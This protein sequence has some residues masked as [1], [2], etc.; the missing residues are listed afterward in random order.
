MLSIPPIGFIWA[1][2]YTGVQEVVTRISF[3]KCVSFLLKSLPVLGFQEYLF[4]LTKRAGEL[5]K[6]SIFVTQEYMYK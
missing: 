3:E 2:D 4:S 5:N 6:T 1:V